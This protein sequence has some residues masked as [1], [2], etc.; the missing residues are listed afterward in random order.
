MSI[1]KVVSVCL[2][3]LLVCGPPAL[4]GPLASDDLMDS[5]SSSLTWSRR[6]VIPVR[7]KTRRPNV[8]KQ[9]NQ[10]FFGG[11]YMPGYGAFRGAEDGGEDY[12]TSDAVYSDC[13]RQQQPSTVI[14]KC[15]AFVSVLVATVT[16]SLNATHTSSPQQQQTSITKSQWASLNPVATVTSSPN[17]G[18]PQQQQASITKSQWAS[19][20]PVYTGDAEKLENIQ[21][22][23]EKFYDYLPWLKGPAGPPGKDGKNGAKGSK[24]DPGIPGIAGPPGPRGFP[25]LRGPS[26]T[27][28]TIG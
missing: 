18:S 14:L 24:G 12:L 20:N 9:G 25:G 17:A 13:V 1:L 7:P 2:V 15:E 16:S 22:Q 8:N 26:G 27:K 5:A 23:W 11:A 21:K 6:G 4:A 10:R 28:L 19:L 3:I